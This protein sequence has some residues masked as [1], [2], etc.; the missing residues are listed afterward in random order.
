MIHQIESYQQFSILVRNLAYLFIIIKYSII[1]FEE[2]PFF[3]FNS[4]L[5]RTGDSYS[6]T[7]TANHISVQ[8]NAL[9]FNN[10]LFFV[11]YIT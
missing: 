9:C 1:N 2:A 8:S 6:T 11:S 3:V 4:G 10:P 7:L 5:A